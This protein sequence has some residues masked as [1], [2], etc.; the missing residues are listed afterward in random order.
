MGEVL[1]PLVVVAAKGQGLPNLESKVMIC[2][3]KNDGQGPLEGLAAGLEALKKRCDAVF[4]SSCDVPF[5]KKHHTIETEDPR[6]DE[7]S[8]GIIFMFEYNGSFH[9][10]NIT[11]A[12]DFDSLQ[13]FFLENFNIQM[14]I[15]LKHAVGRYK[16]ADKK[17][18]TH[19]DTGL[20]LQL[21][22][23]FPP[24]FTNFRFVDD[25]CAGF[26]KNYRELTK[27]EKDTVMKTYEA[28]MLTE[29]PT[30]CKGG[31]KGRKSRKRFRL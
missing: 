21:I 13:E 18:N 31:G 22:D 14:P 20:I 7:Y 3:D 24:E 30:K 11:Y 19:L 12:K 4:L 1:D 8:H 16:S 28:E 5:L 29:T 23:L 9:C 6:K 27:F 2:R 26:T 17:R 15:P 10:F 25:S